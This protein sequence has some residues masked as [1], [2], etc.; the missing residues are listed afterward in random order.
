MKVVVWNEGRVE[1][2]KDIV[3]E[4]YPNLIGGA[5][6]DG[7]AKHGIGA[8]VR[9]IDDHDQ[10]LSQEL[11]DATDVL[12]WWGHLAHN[13]VEDAVVDRVQKRI[14]DGMG[15]VVLHSGH[16]SKIFRRMM[17]TS[18]NLSWREAEGGEDEKVWCLRP[19]HP[20]AEG[21]PPYFDVGK[22]EMYGEPFDIPEPDE[23]VFAS[24]FQGG[25]IF[26][27]GCAYVRGR[28]RIFY[29]SPGHETF[30]IYHNPNV[31][32]VIANAVNW[33]KQRHTSGRILENWN[34]PEPAAEGAP[35]QTRHV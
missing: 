2:E 27:S 10:G 7:L 34:R 17:G 19:S 3:R 11:L 29:F 31:I 14:L 9:N 21:L 30:P 22:D 1:K 28:G 20:V 25:E 15:M 18:C 23:L 16:H 4:I 8:T 5:I 26:R 12:V 24:W 6:A 13:E 32:K 35:Q 33:V